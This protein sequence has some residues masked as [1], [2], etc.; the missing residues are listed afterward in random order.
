MELRHLTLLGSPVRIQVKTLVRIDKGVDDKL[1]EVGA[2][3]ET[4]EVRRAVR[5]SFGKGR[6]VTA[7]K[8]DIGILALFPGTALGQALGWMERRL[9]V[10]LGLPIHFLLVLLSLCTFLILVLSMWQRLPVGCLLTD[11]YDGPG[12]R[13]QVQM[14]LKEEVHRRMTKS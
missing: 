5:F 10:G 11:C 9:I 13:H 2:W 14:K 12:I 7:S 3:K 6:D 1:I 8:Q 4:L